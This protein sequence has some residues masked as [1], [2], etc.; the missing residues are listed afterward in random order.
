[1]FLQSSVSSCESFL[2]LRLCE[3]SSLEHRLQSL[4]FADEG[5]SIDVD[6]VRASSQLPLCREFLVAHESGLAPTFGFPPDNGDPPL[7]NPAAINQV[8]PVVVVI[9]PN[10]A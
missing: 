2:C 1:M 7:V 5:I 6:L 4:G 9:Y 10:V 8:A 3:H